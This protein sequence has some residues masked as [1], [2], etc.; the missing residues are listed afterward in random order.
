MFLILII[1]VIFLDESCA[2]VLLICKARR[3]RHEKL[4]CSAKGS[5]YFIF[6]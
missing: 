3:L 1:A 2:P 6:A 4:G 5:A